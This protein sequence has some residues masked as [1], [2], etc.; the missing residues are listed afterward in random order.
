MIDELY[1]KLKFKA[2]RGMLELDLV[3]NNYLADNY[4][5]MSDLFKKQFD[6]L[7]DLTDPELYDLLINKSMNQLNQSE[8]SEFNDLILDIQKNNQNGQ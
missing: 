2:R 1:K 8:F 4:N 7:M 5:N 6:Q 3:L